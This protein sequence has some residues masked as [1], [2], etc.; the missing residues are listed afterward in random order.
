ML[1]RSMVIG[2][3]ESGCDTWRRVPC[4]VIRDRLFWLNSDEELVSRRVWGK[5][6]RFLQSM[7]SEPLERVVEVHA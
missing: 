4:Q 2:L 7:S 5:Y 1:S 3:F 6:W